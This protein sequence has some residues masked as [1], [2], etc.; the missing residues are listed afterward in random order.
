MALFDKN[1]LP[2]LET[3]LYLS[4]SGG[5]RIKPDIEPLKK[6]WIELLK[7]LPAGQEGEA[8]KEA[9]AFADEIL[10]TAWTSWFTTR[11]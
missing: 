6:E 11:S 7:T 4:A 1:I 3:L 2:K 9:L 8:N 10:K 5:S